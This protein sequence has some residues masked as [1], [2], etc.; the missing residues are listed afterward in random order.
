MMAFDKSLR[1][2]MPDMNQETECDVEI[3]QISSIYPLWKACCKWLKLMVVH[4]DAVLILINHMETIINPKVT[5]KVI[6]TPHLNATLMP[7]KELLN[8]E[9]YFD[10]KA[11]FGAPPGPSTDEIIDFLE[12]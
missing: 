2:M 10:D 4:F 3:Y 8:N 11:P 6:T 7:W 5:I 1:T 12:E 9:R